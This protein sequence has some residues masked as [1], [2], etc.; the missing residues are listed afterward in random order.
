MAEYDF[1]RDY[2]QRQR[3]TA[4]LLTDEEKWRFDKV[5]GTVP[6]AWHCPLLCWQHAPSSSSSCSVLS[7]L[8]SLLSASGPLLRPQ[9]QALLRPQAQAPGSGP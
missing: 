9:A 1:G 7:A 3:I 5:H 6:S 8:L 2:R 4:S